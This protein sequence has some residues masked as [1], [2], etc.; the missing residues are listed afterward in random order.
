MRDSCV[1]RHTSASGSRGRWHNYT[2]NTNTHAPTLTHTH[3]H[4]GGEGS[5]VVVF[6]Q[7]GLRGAL[8]SLASKGWVAVLGC[9]VE[10]CVGQCEISSGG[11]S[12]WVVP[13]KKW[14]LQKDVPRIQIIPPPDPPGGG[15]S[16][17]SHPTLL[18]SALQVRGEG[19]AIAGRQ[20]ADVLAASCKNARPDIETIQ[21]RLC[22]D[23]TRNTA[24]QKC[25]QMSKFTVVSSGARGAGAGPLLGVRNVLLGSVPV[26]SLGELGEQHPQQRGS[27]DSTVRIN[28]HRK[29]RHSVTLSIDEENIWQAQIPSFQERQLLLIAATPSRFS[30]CL[31][32]ISKTY[33]HIIAF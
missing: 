8:R 17:D 4:L 19:T 12:G 15:H 7:V 25:W 24:P 22:G 31:G 13:Q 6:S 32:S 11:P 5:P 2:Q 20:L 23:N 18:S 1:L 27:T 3:T 9:S 30:K 29:L 10:M 33:G 16:G 14:S 21:L 26:G 28:S